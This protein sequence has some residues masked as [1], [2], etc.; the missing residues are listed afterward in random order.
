MLKKEIYSTIFTHIM[1]C[2]NNIN[3]ITAINSERYNGKNYLKADHDEAILSRLWDMV[4]DMGIKLRCFK[5]NKNM[6]TTIK[7][8]VEKNTVFEDTA[9]RYGVPK[10]K[11]ENNER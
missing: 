1:V 10:V 4:H 9:K 6:Y 5:D 3:R 2:V 8:T 7:M 11:E